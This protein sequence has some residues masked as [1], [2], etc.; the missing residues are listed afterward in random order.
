MIYGTWGII[1]Q[2]IGILAVI[3]AGVGS[4]V[5]VIDYLAKFYEIHEKVVKGQKKK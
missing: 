4:L 2:I 3:G 5:F 1:F